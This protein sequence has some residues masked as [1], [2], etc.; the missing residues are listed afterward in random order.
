MIN[1]L[2]LKKIASDRWAIVEHSKNK[3]VLEIG[4][5]NHSISGVK[6]QKRLGTWLFDYL[7]TYSKHATGIDIDKKAIDYLRKNNYDIRFG[8]A[9]NFDLKEKYDVIIASKLIDH[10][11]NLD[12][13]FISCKKHLAPRGKIFISDDNILCIPQLILWYFKKNIGQPDKDITIKV[14]PE[15][16]KLF[17]DRYGLKVEKITYTIGTGSSKLVKIFRLIEK[18]IPK[19]FIYKPLFY[20]HYI[21]QLGHA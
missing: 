3:R 18:L 15:Y 2:E 7:H 6:E 4:C 8:D 14:I 10:L 13:F 12:G 1:L 17:V 20:P 11:L 21:I 9:Q 5:V 19:K 16:F